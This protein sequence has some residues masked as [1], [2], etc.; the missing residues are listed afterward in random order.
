MGGNL[1]GGIECG[2]PC[3]PV[4]RHR[5]GVACCATTYN[6]QEAAAMLWKKCFALSENRSV[7]VYFLWHWKRV[8]CVGK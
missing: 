8:D 2:K 6:S 5:L 3:G 1:V 7:H 4:D